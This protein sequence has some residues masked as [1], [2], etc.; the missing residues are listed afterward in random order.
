VAAD[1]EL[2]PRGGGRLVRRNVTLFG[3]LMGSLAY[4]L[5]LLVAE[6]LLFPLDFARFRGLLRRLAEV[7]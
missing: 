1:P 4:G 5:T 3:L 6:R 7:G 2:G